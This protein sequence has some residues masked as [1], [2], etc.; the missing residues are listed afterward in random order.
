MQN[1]QL[2]LAPLVITSGEPSGIGIDIC[3]DIPSWQLPYPIVVLGDKDLFTQRAIQLN[4][5]ITL[6]D[7][8]PQANWKADYLYIQHIPLRQPCQ[9]GVLNPQNASYVLQLLDTAIAGIQSGLFSGMVTAPIHKGVINEYWDKKTL[10]SGHTE[11]LAEKSNTP[12][13][14][15]MLVGADMRVALLTTH[16][17]LRD[18]PQAINQELIHRIVLIIHHDMQN[19]FGIANPK[20]LFAGLNPHAGEGGYL[21]R[22]ELDIMQPAAQ[23]LRQSGIDISDPLPADTLFQPFLL[24]NADVVL[25]AYHDQG[26]PVLKYASFGEGVNVTL[27][28][29]FI[30][31]SVDHGT[32]LDLAGTGKANSGSLRAAIEMAWQMVQSQHNLNKS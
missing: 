19:K 6:C 21:G 29:P 8:V 32:A 17:P 2:N 12:Q 14:V 5:K 16:L 18:V 15:M 22:E 24:D 28:L 1:P 7:A 13:V 4:K 3:L 23:L 30:R 25:A 26:L 20:I 11:Y 31:T 9:T 10:F 27:G